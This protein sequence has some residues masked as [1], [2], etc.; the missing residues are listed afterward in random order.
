MA[1]GCNLAQGF[2]VAS[3]LKLRHINQMDW[4][5]QSFLWASL[6]WGAVASGYLVYGWKQKSAIPLAGGGAMT[7]ISFLL[8]AFWMSVVSIAIMYAVWWL[9]K[10]GY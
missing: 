1:H 2:S 6:V 9:M 8:P 4:M 10:E 3:R 5:N 7:I